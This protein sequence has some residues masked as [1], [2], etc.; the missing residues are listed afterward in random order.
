MKEITRIEKIISWFKHILYLI[1]SKIYLY[2]IGMKDMDEYTD[3]ILLHEVIYRRTSVIRV[4]EEY[5]EDCGE[6][7]NS[8]R[9]AELLEIIRALKIN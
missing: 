2:S 1:T 8:Q 7:L 5:I 6:M 3:E 4:I 9:K